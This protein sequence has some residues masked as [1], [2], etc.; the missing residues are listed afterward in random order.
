MAQKL[1]EKTL[2][3]WLKC[4]LRWVCAQ[5]VLP[6]R[7]WESAPGMARVPEDSIPTFGFFFTT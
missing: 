7:G 5:V 6:E 4:L 1:P 3:F 2:L